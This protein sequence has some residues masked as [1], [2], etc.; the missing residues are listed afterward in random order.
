VKPDE[1]YEYHEYEPPVDELPDEAYWDFLID[2]EPI[3]AHQRF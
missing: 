2:F 3:N 1:Q